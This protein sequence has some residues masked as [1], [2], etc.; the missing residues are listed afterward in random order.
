MTPPIRH[1]AIRLACDLC[2]R[3]PALLKA[4][5]LTIEEEALVLSTTEPD[6]LLSSQTRRRA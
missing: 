3:N 4:A 6:L 5:T 1:A 2:G